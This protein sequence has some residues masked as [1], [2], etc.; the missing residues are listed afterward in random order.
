M[1]AVA[2]QVDA[3]VQQDALDFVG[4]APELAANRQEGREQARDMRRGHAG[5]A[6]VQVLRDSRSRP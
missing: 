5:A 6:V 2:A 3:A 1:V 4:P